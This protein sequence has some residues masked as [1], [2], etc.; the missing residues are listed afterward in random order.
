MQ[1]SLPKPEGLLSR[2]QAAEFLGN[3]CTTTLDR[4]KI[5]RTVIRRRVFYRL[6]V[7]EKWLADHTQTQAQEGSNE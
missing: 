7:L 1:N 2:K 4:L 5:D 6:D 3:I